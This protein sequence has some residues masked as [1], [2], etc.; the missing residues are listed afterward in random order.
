MNK[1]I[2]LASLSVLVLAVVQIVSV[3]A[4]LQ[5]PVQVSP[6]T[7]VL[8][9]RGDYL[10]V[11]ADIAFSRVATGT[12]TLNGIPASSAFADSC[13]NLVVKFDIER[14]KSIATPPEI[15]LTLAGDCRDGASFEGSATITVR[16]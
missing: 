5:V 14:V 2:L 9:S 10:T 7:L 16:E 8:H 11:H 13:G 15:V 12:L 6:N 3:A 1:P 4:E